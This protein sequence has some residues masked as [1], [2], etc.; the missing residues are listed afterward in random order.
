MRGSACVFHKFATLFL[1]ISSVCFAQSLFAAPRSSQSLDTA[2]EALA[3]DV[4]VFLKN[5]RFSVR[6]EKFSGSA[7]S[8]SGRMLQHQLSSALKSRGI[9]VLQN[10]ADADAGIQGRFS[11]SFED[12]GAIILI[13]VNIV[14]RLGKDLGSNRKAALAENATSLE[15]VASL[16]PTN[17]DFDK[18][19]KDDDSNKPAP[20][21]NDAAQRTDGSTES[22][23]SKSTEI[24]E[25]ILAPTFA[26]I[27]NS[28][29][30]IAPKES[31]QF[32]MEVLV[33]DDKHSEFRELVFLNSGGF[34]F[35]ELAAGNEYQVQ[36]HNLS[37]HPI[38]VKLAVDGINCLA[39][40]ENAEFRQHGMWVVNAKS[41]EVI[42]GWHITEKDIRPFLITAGERYRGQS[43]R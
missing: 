24:K 39:L 10:G 38:G 35:A 12:E 3:A 31:S 15:D 23:S 1:A 27:N 29:T 16:F 28:H 42:S 9:E 33:R 6:V 2:M 11:V 32:Q 22:T 14:D 7:N 30:R 18:K 36:I 40:S 25:A 43:R 41:T 20:G 26:F 13:E 19:N 17:F 37:D 21:T 5:E 34:P 8:S 4:A